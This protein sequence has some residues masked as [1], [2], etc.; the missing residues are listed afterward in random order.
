MVFS[1]I[2]CCCSGSI[3]SL[4]VERAVSTARCHV[5]SFNSGNSMDRLS[6][7]IL[8]IIC[9]S[10]S[11][12]STLLKVQA[13][14]RDDESDHCGSF[15]CRPCQ[16]MSCRLET[17]AIVPSAIVPSAI[18]PLR[19]CRCIRQGCRFRNRII[20]FVKQNIS[21]FFSSRFQSNQLK[22]LSWQ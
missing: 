5:R 10:S 17:S 12:A 14:T 19:Y 2:A 7:D 8:N 15:N 11:S 1:L 3:I 18:V 20:P 21:R 22:A 13:R 6:S 9:R 4:R 16:V